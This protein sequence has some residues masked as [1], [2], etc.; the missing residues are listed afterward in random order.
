MELYLA[1]VIVSIAPR[2]LSVYTLPH[3]RPRGGPKPDV[4]CRSRRRS[5]IDTMLKEL[6]WTAGS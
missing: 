5:G 2:R 1:T 6:A 4:S 3:H